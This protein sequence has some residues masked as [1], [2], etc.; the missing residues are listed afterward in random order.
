MFLL[1]TLFVVSATLGA[2]WLAHLSGSLDLA[3]VLAAIVLAVIPT[4]GLACLLLADAP[5]PRGAPVVEGA[6]RRGPPGLGCAGMLSG[7]E[8]HPHAAA[9]LGAALP[10]QP[11]RTPSH[12]Y[13]FHGPAGS[14]KRAVARA[15]AAALLSDGLGATEAQ[16]VAAR[17]E[18]GAHPDLTWVKPTQRGGN[19]GRATS[20]R[21]SSRPRRA[22]R[23]RR[24]AGC[25]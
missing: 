10:C 2:A 15:F 3:R 12:A 18:H 7:T 21:R 4:A 19:S 16:A 25:S 24:A 9:V 20:T 14:G 8:R 6:P 22:R 17:V 13:L 23:S 11:G 1:S 5:A